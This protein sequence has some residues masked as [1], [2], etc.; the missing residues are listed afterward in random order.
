MY[1]NEHFDKGENQIESGGIEDVRLTKLETQN[2]ILRYISVSISG[3]VIFLEVYVYGCLKRHYE[4]LYDDLTWVTNYTPKMV[5]YQQNLWLFALRLGLLVINSVPKMNEFITGKMLGGEYRYTSNVII[6]MII[7]FRAPLCVNSYIFSTEWSSEKFTNC[8]KKVEM[9]LTYT[10]FLKLEAKYHPLRLILVFSS[11]LCIYCGVTLY[12][13]ERSFDADFAPSWN[14]GNPYNNLWL[15]VVTMTTV[16]YGD[17]YPATYLGRVVAVIACIGG[18]II[19]SF[20]LSFP[21]FPLIELYLGE[22]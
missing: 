5:M 6:F 16:G 8:L 17:G 19:I 21:F 10:Y 7:M 18:K 20:L 3:F 13:L 2:D 1:E 15:S 12:Y 11:L 14:K 4:E 22:R 9:D